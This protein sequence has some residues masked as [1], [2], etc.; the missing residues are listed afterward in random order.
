MLMLTVENGCRE[1]NGGCS[2]LCISTRISHYCSCERGYQL[3][4][5]N[6]TCDGI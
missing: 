6:H 3:A 5:D 4:S 1:N 2:G